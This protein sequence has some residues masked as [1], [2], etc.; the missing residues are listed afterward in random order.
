MAAWCFL[1]FYLSSVPNLKT[2]QNPFWDEIIRS[3]LHLIFYA[4]LFVLFFRAINFAK[5]KKNFWGPL[6]LTSFYGLSDEVHQI[7]VP[8]R[9]FQWQ[10]LAIDIL[11]ALLG[12]LILWQLGLRLPEKFKTL[13]RKL[14]II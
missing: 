7:L 13:A 4:I 9:T 5:V 3:S 2:A 8:T 11:G 10:D 1:L 12:S 6:F 14:L